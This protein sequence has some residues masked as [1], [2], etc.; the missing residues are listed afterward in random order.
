MWK[1]IFKFLTRFTPFCLRRIHFSIIVAAVPSS[2]TGTSF[3]A[4]ASF[5]AIASSAAAVAAVQGT[6]RQ[7]DPWQPAVGKRPGIQRW[8]QEMQEPYLGH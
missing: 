1:K 2:V 6:W 8:D 4:T 5:A 3:T 7:A